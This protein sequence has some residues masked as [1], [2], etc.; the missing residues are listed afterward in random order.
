M[1]DASLSPVGVHA[2]GHAQ[3]YSG[4]D[5]HS[6]E[7][8]TG[9][10]NEIDLDEIFRMLWRRRFV[11][12]SSIS[13]TLAI[14]VVYLQFAKPVYTAESL[15]QIEPASDNI[16]GI[17]KV[18]SALSDD[19]AAITGEVQVI[20]SRTIAEA[21]VGDLADTLGAEVQ[22]ARQ[23]EATGS[24][25][26]DR[27][28]SH[29]T[30]RQVQRSNVIS[31]RFDALSAANAAAAANAV[32][33][34]YIESQLRNKFD[35][36]RRATDWINERLSELEATV[37][38]SEREIEDF[39][40]RVGLVEGVQAP[41]LIEQ[42]SR[43]NA[44]LAGAEALATEAEARLREAEGLSG[45]D[46]DTIAAVLGSTPIQNL[47][48]DAVAMSQRE[49]ELSVQYGPEHPVWEKVRAES[50]ILQTKIDEEVERVVENLSSE[51]RVAQSRVSTLGQ[52]VQ[53]LE[54]V[55]TDASL[56][57]VQLRA[58]ERDAEADRR[59]YELFLARFKE[60]TI[61]DGIQQAD[62][63]VVSY[64]SVPS[65]P[66]APNKPVLLA[67]AL[68]LALLLGLTLVFVIERLD[69]LSF[70]TSR[71]LRQ[72]LG[73]P[74]LGQ[75]PEVRAA[76]RDQA[77][78]LEKT[79]SRSSFAEAMRGIRASLLLRTSEGTSQV[80]LVTSSLPGEGKTTTTVGL[81]RAM[82]GMGHRVLTVDCDLRRPR[83]HEVLGVPNHRGLAEYLEEETE[84]ELA[85]HKDEQSDLMFVTAGQASPTA[86]ELLQTVRI[87]KMLKRLRQD[88]DVIFLDAP[89][90][91]AVVDPRILARVADSTV[92]LV[93][94]KET[95]RR[96]AQ[97]AVEL[98]LESEPKALGCVMTQVNAR[99]MSGYGYGDAG[100]FYG[101]GKC[102]DY[103]STASGAS[104]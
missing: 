62:A 61:Q 104:S 50:T 31:V 20:R 87:P 43:L 44:E 80:V 59:L 18:A 40:A 56:A 22:G 91:L 79:G 45:A 86:A 41:L 76:A 48:N 55:A 29:L 89:P 54:A 57:G 84:A 17:E 49:A 38:G 53:E 96:V 42:L 82:A 95:R 78:L 32:A 73:L 66:S 69:Q 35:A 24:G 37:Q 58:L 100:S 25:A 99:V 90:V 30:V 85:A 67:A 51:V 34:R 26:V 74:V 13:V 5:Y 93:K 63:R 47:R 88:F 39:R 71:E 98:L 92:F 60:T 10:P 15:I 19:T 75:I 28:L 2:S 77:A 8:S 52:R 21:V 9:S 101:H 14:A 4:P 72:V 7:I 46:I 6:Y 103:Y 16:V 102:A 65:R 94:W 81:A 83:L 27:F 64:A 11:L 3:P 70:S 68:V 23:P 1:A 97:S 36:T 33:D 12:L